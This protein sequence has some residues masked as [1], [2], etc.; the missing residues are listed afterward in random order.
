MQGDCIWLG[1][2][3]R[4]LQF[5]EDYNATLNAHSVDMYMENMV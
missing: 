3:L 5:S 4:T 1:Y 2:D